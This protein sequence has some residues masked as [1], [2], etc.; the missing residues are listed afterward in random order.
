MGN[1]DQERYNPGQ[2]R[3]RRLELVGEERTGAR[4]GDCLLLARPFFLVPSTS[5]R[6]RRLGENKTEQQT[7]IPQIKDESAQKPKRA[8]F[9][10]LIYGTG[11][12]GG[13]WEG[14]GGINFPSILSNIV[15]RPMP[16]WVVYQN[17]AIRFCQ[18]L[19]DRR[20]LILLDRLA[21]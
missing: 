8:I 12:G 13:G 16:G 18:F 20:L 14:V 3:N 7:P 15:D 10:S 4:E 1:L 17:T 21:L 6:L 9:L 11:G 2:N 5:K 19:Y